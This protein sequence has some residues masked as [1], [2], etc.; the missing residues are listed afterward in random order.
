MALSDISLTA[1]MRSNLV[2]LQQTEALLNRTQSRLASGKKVNSSLDDPVNFFAALS[3][4]S[5]ANG[6]TVLKDAMNEAIQTV[7]AAD[8]GIKGITALIEQAKSIADSAKATDVKASRTAYALQYDAIRTQINELA[9]DS[10]YRGVNFL[11]GTTNVLDVNFNEAGSSDLAITGF[12]ASVTG[13]AIDAAT[14]AGWDT[15]AGATLTAGEIATANAVIDADIAL[16]NTAKTTL[17]T[18]SSSLSSNLNVITT[19]LDFTTSIV[20]VL[21]DGANKLTL[22]DMNEEGANMLALQTRQALSTTSLSL[23][24]QAAQSILRLF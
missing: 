12:D 20:N 4:T 8:T 7:K 18:N 22:A 1:G 17:Q 23:S 10:G 24:A 13:L 2:S 19:R 16:L 15:A 3:H 11:G 9:L 6:L 14:G 5:R 21:V